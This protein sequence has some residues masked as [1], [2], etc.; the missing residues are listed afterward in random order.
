MK[1]LFFCFLGLFFLFSCS[2]QAQEYDKILGN[3]VEKYGVFKGQEGIVSASFEKSQSRE[4]LM[5]VYIKDKAVN[6]EAYSDE[7]GEECLDSL[8]FV[9]GGNSEYVFSL[10]KTA[11]GE[12]CVCVST[13]G[14]DEF[15]IIQ[16]DAFTRIYDAQVYDKKDIVISNPEGIICKENPNTVY[17]LL[18]YFKEEKIKAS[19]F[20]DCKN[21]INTATL[22]SIKNTLNAV[23]DVVR[24][25]RK[26]GDFAELLKNILYTYENYANFSDIAPEYQANS[27]ETGF[28][29]IQ[30]VNGEYIDF[31]LN[32]IFGTEPQHMS[33]NN[34]IDKGVCYTNGKYFFT[35]GYTK[36]FQTEIKDIR[37]IYDLGKKRYYV[38]FYDEYTEGNHTVPEYSYAILDGGNIFSV[39]KLE[40]G[41]TLLEDN[42]IA[43]FSQV[44]KSSIFSKDGDSF[45]HAEKRSIVSTALTVISILAVLGGVVAVVAVIFRKK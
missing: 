39:Q 23:R 10:G 2:V 32:N 41:A 9:Y 38:V 22:E 6:Y 1:K 29:N 3:C 13:D 40:M 17:E 14:T 42:E 24:F 21:T 36:D 30:S 26:K 15:F 12:S 18:N 28:E 35:G 37:S 20:T 11:G 27:P 7:D 45:L 31:I 4:I 34:L 33:V 25:E 8:K 5:V 16:D 44:R 43:Q 19:S